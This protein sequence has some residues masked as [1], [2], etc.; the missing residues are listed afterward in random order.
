LGVAAAGLLAIGMG[1]TQPA[2]SSL[3]SFEASVS[4]QGGIMGVNQSVGS[5]AR[6]IGPTIGGFAF[7]DWGPGA[8]Y[9][10][11]AIA[12]LVS[13]WLALRVVR[14]HRG[15]AGVAQSANG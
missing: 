3:V 9:V 2:T 7:N 1:I 14:N 15:A 8:P 13:S 11:G 6:I 12:M 5:L 4:E 10:L